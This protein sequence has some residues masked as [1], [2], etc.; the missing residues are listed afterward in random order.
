MRQGVRKIKNILFYCHF[1][2]FID[3]GGITI[4]FSSSKN[5]ILIQNST[6][7]KNLA[8]FSAAT[9]I[10]SPFGNIVFRTCKFIQNNATSLWF[11]NPTGVGSVFSIGGSENLFVKTEYCLYISNFAL[12]MGLFYFFFL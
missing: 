2:F 4:N 9:H 10:V 8:S 11:E 6:F 3:G 12:V 5:S 7:E 1:Y